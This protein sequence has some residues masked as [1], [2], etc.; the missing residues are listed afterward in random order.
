M[1]Y[2]A[3]NGRKNNKFILKIVQ[4]ISGGG[5]GRF[6]TGQA[7]ILTHRLSSTYLKSTTNIYRI[8]KCLPNDDHGVKEI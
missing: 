4:I 8:G 6:S 1:E 2:P 3:F 5:G 7:V